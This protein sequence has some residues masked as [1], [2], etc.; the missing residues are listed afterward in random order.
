MKLGI[1]I[2][3]LGIIAIFA[4][5]LVDCHYE[6]IILFLEKTNVLK[7]KKGDFRVNLRNKSVIIGNKLIKNGH[8]IGVRN[9]QC[10]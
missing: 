3:I 4:Q 2:E 6:K 5:T 8:I 1:K 10:R 9:Y 7:I